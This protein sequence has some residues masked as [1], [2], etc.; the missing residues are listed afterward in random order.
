MKYSELFRWQVIEKGNGWFTCFTIGMLGRLQCLQWGSILIK[1]SLTSGNLC[2]STS[3]CLLSAGHAHVPID[4]H[5]H[6][7][8]QPLSV[9]FLCSVCVSVCGGVGGNCAL[10]DRQ[11]LGLAVWQCLTYCLLLTEWENKCQQSGF[12]CLYNLTL[13]CWWS[14]DCVCVCVL[15]LDSVALE[16]IACALLVDFKKRVL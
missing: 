3:V 7:S 13:T 5:K 4:A 12:Y 2:W 16:L 1:Q 9:Y 6:V 10:L 15:A 11:V 14:S 8:P